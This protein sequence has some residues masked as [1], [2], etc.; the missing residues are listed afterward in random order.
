MNRSRLSSVVC[1]PLTGNKTWEGSP[2]N[3][4]LHAY[5]TGLPKDSIAVVAHILAVEKS[6]LFERVGK[7]SHTQFSLLLAGIDTML[8]R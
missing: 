6:L 2:G 1:V 4:E 5:S 7:L 8:G 3:L